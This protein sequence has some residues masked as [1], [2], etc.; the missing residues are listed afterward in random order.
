MWTILLIAMIQMPQLALTAGISSI[1]AYFDMP[2]AAV[3]T[4][5]ALPNLISTISGIFAAILIQF[6]VLPKK[7]SV[8]AGVAALSAAAIIAIFFHSAFWQVYLFSVLIGTGMGMFIPTAQSILL[9]TFDARALQILTGAQASF[10][11]GG[12]V[13]LSVLGGL[14]IT[15]T[16]RWY[17]VYVMLLVTLPVAVIAAKTLPGAKKSERRGK[18]GARR[19]NRLPRDVYYYTAVVLVYMLF[20]GTMSVNLSTHIAD[21]HI[22]NA[23]TA[24]VALAFMMA[25][26]VAAGFIF[27]L[28]SRRLRDNMLTLSFFV[29]FVGYTLINLF[30]ASLAV[31]MLSALLCGTTLPTTLPQCIFAV[32]HIVDP[33]NSS[34]ASMLIGTLAS[35]VGSFLSPVLFTNLT[36]ALFGSSTSARYQFVGILS[37]AAAILMFFNNVRR[38]K[39]A[40][41]AV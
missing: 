8:V 34:T 1:K 16:G 21:Y 15:L 32:S 5:V 40:K 9:D 22:G 26:G 38:D 18:G 2:E 19:G 39:K 27:P 17:S 12:G 37:L 29:L 41:A 28:L 31:I 7:N 13:I 10:I 35:G 25:G 36:E 3:Q 11:N 4:A 23:A 30:P 33:S 20:N 24:G 14:L 6:G